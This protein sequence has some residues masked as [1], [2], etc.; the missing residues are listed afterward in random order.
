MVPS[1]TAG[2]ADLVTMHI[3]VF[4]VLALALSHFTIFYTLIGNKLA[5]IW[6]M[7]KSCGLANFYITTLLLVKITMGLTHSL[8]NRYPVVQLPVLLSTQLVFNSRITRSLLIWEY[9]MRAVIL[10]FLMAE[11]LVGNIYP[12]SIEFL[13]EYVINLLFV[14]TITCLLQILS[15][16][17]ANKELANAICCRKQP[18]ITSDS[19]QRKRTI[20]KCSLVE[21]PHRIS[22]SM[23]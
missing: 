16:C 17:S 4:F 15:P 20:I 14:I 7:W 6:E 2:Y 3:T 5:A 9:L 13:E 23:L 21:P 19:T 10:L 8:L 18:T 1:G 12:I 22:I 11:M